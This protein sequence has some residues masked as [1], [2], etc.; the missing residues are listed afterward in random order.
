MSADGTLHI[1]LL[2]YVYAENI[3]FWA[4]DLKLVNTTSLLPIRFN[5]NNIVQIP[6]VQ[7]NNDD[8]LGQKSKTIIKIE[9]PLGTVVITIEKDD[10]KPKP[11]KPFED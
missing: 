9:T 11:M 2:T 3:T 5:I 10:G 8:I 4:I 1:P 6:E 7:Q